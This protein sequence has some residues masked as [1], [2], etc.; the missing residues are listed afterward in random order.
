MSIIFK[1]SCE[2][3]CLRNAW[4]EAHITSIHRKGNMILTRN[5]RPVSLASVID[6][7]MESI[8]RNRLVKHMPE[9]DLFY[10]ILDSDS[11]IDAIYLDFRKAF[12][13]IPYQTPGKIGSLWHQRQKIINVF[14]RVDQ[15]M[16]LTKMIYSNTRGHSQKMARLLVR[17]GIRQHGFS[18]RIVTDWNSIPADMVECPTL[19]SFK[20][21]L[22]H[23]RGAIQT[24]STMIAKR[25]V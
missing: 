16:F 9:Y 10:D 8:V 4:K 22:W 1:I 11:P 6:T 20:S 23:D 14:Y 2:E 24:S 7:I 5:Y 18:H 12:D 3:S 13:T 25:L 17:L 21:R 15:S 19:N